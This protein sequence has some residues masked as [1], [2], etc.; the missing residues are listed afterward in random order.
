[1]KLR[2]ITVATVALAAALTMS[3]CSS[4]DGGSSSETAKTSTTTTAAAPVADYPP[5]PSPEELNADLARAFDLNV[6]ASEKT[7][8]V[9][10]AEEDPE[11][12]NKVA[13]AANDAGVQVNVVDVTDNENGTITAGVEMALAGSNQPSFGTVDFVAEDGTWKVSKDYACSIVINMA[14]LQSPACA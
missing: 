7:D 12:I 9:Q 3:A 2:K 5:V 1:M 4:D 11:L 14:Q 10:G 13:Q 8:L 6:P